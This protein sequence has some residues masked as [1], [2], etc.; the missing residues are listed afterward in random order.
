MHTY[1]HL[2]SFSEGDDYVV[3]FIDSKTFEVTGQVAIRD[4]SAEFSK[5]SGLCFLIGLEN[6]TISALNGTKIGEPW[7]L[8]YEIN[9]NDF[10]SAPHHLLQTPL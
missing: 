10:T 3:K 6:N 1:H 8:G 9:R 5:I 7:N 2:R 4:D